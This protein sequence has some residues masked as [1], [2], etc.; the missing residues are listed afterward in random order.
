MRN[1][2]YKWGNTF[3][4]TSEN[5][6]VV[7]FRSLIISDCFC[8][9]CC[10]FLITKSCPTLSDHMDCSLPSSSVQGIS[11]ARI[12]KWAVISSRGSSWPRYWTSVSCLAGISLGRYLLLGKQILYHWSTWEALLIVISAEI[13]KQKQN[14]QKKNWLSLTLSHIWVKT[15]MRYVMYLK[16]FLAYTKY[17]ILIIISWIY[18]YYNGKKQ[19]QNVE[20]QF[21][22]C[23]HSLV[24]CIFLSPTDSSITW[25]N[26]TIWPQIVLLNFKILICSK[27]HQSLLISMIFSVLFGYLYHWALFWYLGICQSLSLRVVKAC[28][29]N[30]EK[31]IMI[32]NQCK[33]S[34]YFDITHNTERNERNDPKTRIY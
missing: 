9:C 5:S 12:L 33:I 29:E 26:C 32:A 25:G 11:Q 6:S 10:C 17:I 2:W 30:Y 7:I 18:E 23:L 22:Y 19:T 20:A 1:W 3:R 24:C 27:T 34:M 4:S 28:I 16:I 13:G 21:Y 31:V 14:K 15:M 8:C